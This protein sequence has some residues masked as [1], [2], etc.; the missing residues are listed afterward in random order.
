M[1]KV[2]ILLFLL[3]SF[4]SRAQSPVA[5][6][7]G[8][9]GGILFPSP[10]GFK[11]IYP[12]DILS[13]GVSAGVGYDWIYAVGR[14]R[15]FSAG[16]TPVLENITSNTAS[17]SWEQAGFQAGLRFVKRNTVDFHFDV[18]YYSTYAKEEILLNDPDFTL[19]DRTNRL[20]ATGFSLGAGIDKKIVTFL[21]ANLQAELATA[22]T[23][24][25]N[26]ISG[27]G[28]NLGYFFIG[29]GLSAKIL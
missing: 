16:G 4:A 23:G 26:G 15:K 19:L 12:G 21:S 24:N 1:N 28:I 29:I 14:Y 9:D 25:K 7:I 17:A 20:R 2:V 3:C 11:D 27:K 6:F 22:R 8:L 13:P 18:L 10:A 5:A